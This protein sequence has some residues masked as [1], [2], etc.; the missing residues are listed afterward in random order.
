MEGEDEDEDESSDNYSDD[1]EDDEVG[2]GGGGGHGSRVLKFENGKTVRL[3]ADHGAADTADVDE[4][5]DDEYDHEPQEVI[6]NDV[7]VDNVG[8]PRNS[9]HSEQ[10]D[11][12][13][14]NFKPLDM[15]FN[16]PHLCAVLQVETGVKN[17]FADI[18]NQEI[19]ALTSLGDG[20]GGLEDEPES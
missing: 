20:E 16:S 3:T 1:F 13:K 2:A 14:L 17:P 15:G 11:M 4:E 9:G 6:D 19:F 8:V 10:S 7:D 5:G 12:V 18:N